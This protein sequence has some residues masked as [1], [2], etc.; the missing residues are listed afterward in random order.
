MANSAASRA[1]LKIRFRNLNIAVI[2]LRLYSC[3]ISEQ[4]NPI[5]NY[6]FSKLPSLLFLRIL[7]RDGEQQKW[8]IVE[9]RGHF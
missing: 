5:G 2:I 9:R 7:H 8:R 3:I 6:M 4:L 1:F